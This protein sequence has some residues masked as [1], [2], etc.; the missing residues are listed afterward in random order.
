MKRLSDI[1]PFPFKKEENIII[2]REMSKDCLPGIL[3][4]GLSSYSSPR[5]LIPRKMSG[6]PHI[7]TDF[8]HV[9]SRLFRLNCSFPLICMLFK[10]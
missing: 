10:F 2:D 1:R 6:I 4:K 7:I 9:I 5:M 8:R 3:R